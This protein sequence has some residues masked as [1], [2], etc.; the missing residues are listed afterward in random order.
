MNNNKQIAQD[1]I[2]QAL[3][4]LTDKDLIPHYKT[5]YSPE[6]VTL[7]N[8]DSLLN[9]K[10][11]NQWTC[12]TILSNSCNEL[13]ANYNNYLLDSYKTLSFTDDRLSF[14]VLSA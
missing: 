13:K 6:S 12:L 7:D 3:G 8:L 4:N 1:E 14:G 10:S 2:K 5:V 11:I 9:Q